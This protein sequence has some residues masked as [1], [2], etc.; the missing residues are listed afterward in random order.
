MDRHQ[1][2]ED[3]LCLQQ[4]YRDVEDE[5]HWIK[6]HHPLAGSFDLGKSLQ[7]VQNLQKKHQALLNE[8]SG[9]E[10]SVEKVKDRGEELMEAEHFA[11][12]DIQQSLLELQSCWRE[13]KQLA[14]HRTKQLSDSQ[15]AQKVQ[16]SLAVHF[17]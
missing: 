16:L 6:E 9:R 12:D 1:Q 15:E 5:H 2:L 3:S 8:I 10:P 13:L 7:E 17:K 14:G 11:S 4:F